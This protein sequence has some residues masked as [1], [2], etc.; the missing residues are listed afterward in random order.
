[1]LCEMCG[2]EVPR[3][4]LVMVEGAAVNVCQ[5]CEKFA[6]SAAV[7]TRD[8]DIVLPDVAERLDTRE[9]RR[10]ERDVY[11]TPGDN[12]LALDYSEKIRIARQKLG[13]NQEE[14]GLLINEKKGVIV[15]VEN[16]TM[17]PND[18]LVS[19]LEKT[20]KISLRGVIEQKGEIKSSDQ[21]RGLTLG[22]FIKVKEKK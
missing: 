20:L 18:K 10:K 9:K 2:A 21:S 15:N 8:G 12:E 1:M 14:L 6:T 4:K 19:K 7:K 22:D 3:A 11:E 13:M 17:T 16:G 5:K